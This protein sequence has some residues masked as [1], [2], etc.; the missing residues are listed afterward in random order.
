MLSEDDCWYCTRTLKRVSWNCSVIVRVEW[1]GQHCTVVLQ[2]SVGGRKYRWEIAPV[3]GTL[4]RR[5]NTHASHGRR[6]STLATVAEDQNA[7]TKLS[8][9]ARPPVFRRN[10]GEASVNCTLKAILEGWTCAIASDTV[11]TGLWRLD[12]PELADLL[13]IDSSSLLL[14]SDKGVLVAIWCKL[15]RI[16]G[17]TMFPSPC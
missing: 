17:T 10:R 3:P 1:L 13:R 4:R 14:P 7:S 8:R 5:G 12:R 9:V 11:Q 2:V 15:R 6:S 16:P